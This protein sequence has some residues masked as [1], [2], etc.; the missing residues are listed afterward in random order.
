MASFIANRVAR[1]TIQKH[2]QAMEPIDPH[3]E[4][5]SDLWRSGPPGAPR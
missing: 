1:G 5:S 2:A 4:V 3:Y